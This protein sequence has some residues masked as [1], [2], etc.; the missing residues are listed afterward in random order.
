MLIYRPG[1]DLL[2]ND[3]EQK[4]SVLTNSRTSTVLPKKGETLYG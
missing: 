1:T 4:G 3:N 2:E